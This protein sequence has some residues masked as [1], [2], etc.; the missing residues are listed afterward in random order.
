MR[1]YWTLYWLVRICL[2]LYLN[3]RVEGVEHIPRTGPLIVIA[4][5]RSAFD[6][7][8][9]GALLPRAVHFMT[10]AELFNYPVL[11]WIF[12]HVQ[13]YPVHRGH[14]DRRA[15]R[16]S[17]EVINGGDAILMFP[18]GHRTETGELQEARAGVVYLAQKTGAPLVPVG[19]S[20]QY[21]FRRR[22]SAKI[23]QPFHIPPEMNKREAQVLV[24]DKIR[25]LVQQDPSIRTG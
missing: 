25:E 21:G 22:I 20:G 16:H 10:K 6:P 3:I 18:E 24:M 7:P 11:P 17:L 23:G 8:L 9:V 13:A 4:N 15:I 19:I 5:H 14:P 12:R 2:S 1:I